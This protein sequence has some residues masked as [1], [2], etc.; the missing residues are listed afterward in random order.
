MPIPQDMARRNSERAEQGR[1][2]D[3][4]P[5][6]RPAPVVGDEVP[7]RQLY[8]AGEYPLQGTAGDGLPAYTSP[9]ENVNGRDIVLWY[10]VALTHVPAVEE[11][12][13]MTTE[14]TSFQIE[15]DGFFDANPALDAPGE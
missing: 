15:P 2:R 6:V 5:P 12:P 4:R 7:R 14:T 1:P 11:Y 8:A 13:V 9:A 3:L 10:S